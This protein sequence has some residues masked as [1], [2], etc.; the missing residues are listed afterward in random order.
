MRLSKL[1]FK[2]TR[3]TPRDVELISHKFLLRG[4]F[5]KQFSSGI[6]GLSTLSVRIL[7]KIERICREEMEKI[8]GQEVKASCLS[9]KEL[10]TESGRFD[11][12]GQ[13]LFKLE[14]RTKKKPCF[15]PNS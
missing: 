8:G 6:Y 3:E 9:P 7:H 1:F 5:I 15:K 12:F 10:W 2:T 11:N 13:S 4:G 14:D